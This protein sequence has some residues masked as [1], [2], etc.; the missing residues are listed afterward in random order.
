MSN[1]ITVVGDTIDYS[2]LLVTIIGRLYYRVSNKGD[3][4]YCTLVML[5]IIEN[6]K[7]AYIS[8]SFYR[9][10]VVV[11]S[12]DRGILCRWAV[13]EDGVAPAPEI[14]FGDDCT[15]KGSASILMGDDDPRQLM[16][17]DGHVLGKVKVALRQSGDVVSEDLVLDCRSAIALNPTFDAYFTLATVNT[18]RSSRMGGVIENRYWRGLGRERRRTRR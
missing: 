9:V 1:T 17:A 11:E 5:S 14:S 15:A 18:F 3:Q 6:I 2:V 8:V 10:V 13:E 4:Y 16:I 12:L 7:G